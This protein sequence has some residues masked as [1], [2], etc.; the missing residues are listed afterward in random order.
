MGNIF[1]EDF[2]LWLNSPESWLGL[3]TLVKG[4]PTANS[5]LV[6]LLGGMFIYWIS[7]MFDV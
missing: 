1:A 2:V 4:I 3:H 7:S 5:S 6:L